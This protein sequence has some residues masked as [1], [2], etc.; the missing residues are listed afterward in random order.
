VNVK[1]I[2]PRKSLDPSGKTLLI[3]LGCLLTLGAIA[4]GF[5]HSVG[6]FRLLFPLLAS[7]LISA[8]SGMVVIPLLQRLKTGQI[9][10]E[11][12]PEAHL[13]KAGTPT[14]G[15]IFFFLFQWQ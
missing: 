2:S 15:G 13:K 7:A 14:M 1:L 3:F 10:R 11:D 8:V 12:G 4:V 6:Q 9:I 5:S